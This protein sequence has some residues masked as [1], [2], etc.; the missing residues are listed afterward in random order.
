[1]YAQAVEVTGYSLEHLKN[2]KWVAG[3]YEPSLRRDNLPWSHHKEAASLP[4]ADRSE[5]LRLRSD[6]PRSAAVLAAYEPMADFAIDRR[7]PPC[8]EVETNPNPTMI[9]SRLAWA[10][11]R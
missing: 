8:P 5:A 6:T 2:A 4:D 9:S 3:A 7:S 11:A 10:E 1:M